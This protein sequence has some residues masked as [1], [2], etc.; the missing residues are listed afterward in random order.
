[1]DS[2]QTPSSLLASME[3]LCVGNVIVDFFARGD[4]AFAHRHGID[5]PAQHLEHD[6]LMAAI[7]ELPEKVSCSGGGAANVAKI[8][9]LLG[10][11]A[12]FIGAAGAGTAGG[13]D[14]LGRF[15]AGEMAAAG[16][17]ATLLPR[18]A[19]TG[20]CLVLEIPAEKGN[21]VPVRIAAAP[22]ASL[23]LDKDDIEEDAIRRTGVVVID[24]YLMSRQDLVRHILD[25]ANRNGTAVALDLGSPL[26]ARERAHEIATYS[27]VYPLILF[28]NEN[29][30][31]A[32]YQTLA[33]RESFDKDDAGEDRE[34]SEDMNDF[35][36]GLTVNELFPIVVIKRGKRGAIVF[37]GGNVYKENT[38]AVSPRDSTGAGDAFCAAFLAG[39]IRGKPLG[40]CAVMG[41][42]VAREVL[43]VPGTGVN[44][45]RIAAL[46]R[47]LPGKIGRS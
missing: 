6:K 13:L 24:G 19:P 27:R 36:K 41:N 39:W 29:E 10:I 18:N 7:N 3:I 20:C 33:N 43:A 2:E 4:A 21:Q 11:N 34:L 45:K 12:G 35:F 8:A 47:Q 30:A 42:K 26:I 38:F 23:E 14:E 37:A 5:E 44:R 16:V 32:F 1:M 9:A 31:Q 15:F 22:S 28:M 25:L 46:G 17:Q 40:E